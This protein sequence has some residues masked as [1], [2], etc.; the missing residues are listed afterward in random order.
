[1]INPL[2]LIL[3]SISGGVAGYITNK[4]AVNMLFKEYTPLKLGGVV[5]KNKEK[6]IDEISTLVEKD[7]I[8]GKTLKEHIHGEEFKK[9]LDI[10]VEEFWNSGLKEV[11]NDVKIKDISSFE[12]SK[13]SILEFTESKMKLVSDKLLKNIVDNVKITE[14][15]S[16]KHISYITDIVYEEAFKYIKSE[17]KI[18][19]LLTDIYHQNNSLII[20]DIIDE[21]TERKIKANIEEFII[22]SLEKILT[23]KEKLSNIIGR[24]CDV[25][26]IDEI[27]NNL[28][29]SIGSNT[30]NDYFSAEEKK[31]ISSALFAKGS[32]LINSDKGAYSVNTI[33]S[34]LIK[35]AK[36]LDFTLY[37]LLPEE[38][39]INLSKFIEEMTIKAIPSISE[40]IRFN[41]NE[42]NKII[43]DSIDESIEGMNGSIKRIIVQKVR[44][45]L[46]SDISEKASVVDKIISYID[47]YEINEESVKKIS[48]GIITYLESNKV[49]DIIVKL[50]EANIISSDKITALSKLIIEKI[51]IHGEKILNLLVES[52]FSKKISSFIT[53]ESVNLLKR[54]VKEELFLLIYKERKE[55]LS[56]LQPRVINSINNKIEEVIHTPM[57]KF[58]PEEKFTKFLKNVD[59][60][61]L[62]L[63]QNNKRE[64]LEPINT[65]IISKVAEIDLIKVLDNEKDKLENFMVKLVVNLEKEIISKYSENTL[66][67][68][69]DYICNKEKLIETSK[70]KLYKYID[71]NIEEM[72]NGNIKNIIYDNLIKFNEEE[73]CDLAQAFMGNE[74][75]PLSVFGGIL[76]LIVGCI[77]GLF[78]GNASI[79]GFSSSIGSTV[80]SCIIM[81]M[82]G[83]GTNVI[84][85]KMLFYPYKRNK[86]LAKIPFLRKFSL[87]YIPAHKDIMARGIGYVIDEELLNGERV[88]MLLSSKKDM[89]KGYLISSISESNYKVIM[90]SIKEKKET[91]VDFLYNGMKKNIENNKAKIAERAVEGIGNVSVEK[92]VKPRTISKIIL[93]T[94]KLSLIF[95]EKTADYLEDKIKT[96]KKCKEFMK[97]EQ[98]IKIRTDVNSS[99][100]DVLLNK[101]KDILNEEN[102]KKIILKGEDK[103]QTIIN[104]PLCEIISKEKSENLRKY[105]KDK[106]MLWI[107]NESESYFE[108]EISGFLQKE[109]DGDNTIGNVFGGKLAA[110]I[111]SNIPKLSRYVISKGENYLKANRNNFSEKVRN[112]I[113]SGLNFL[114]RGAYMMFGGDDIVDRCVDT[115][116]DIKVPIFLDNKYLE[117]TS[118]VQNTLSYSVYPTPI[119][120]LQLKAKEIN[121]SKVLDSIYISLN[122]S[123]YVKENI[124]DVIDEAINIILN[125]NLKEFLSFTDLTSLK[126][127]CHKFSNQLKLVIEVSRDNLVNNI[128]EIIK[129]TD[130]IID[131]EFI[132]HIQE[133]AINK[134]MLAV[135]REDIVRCTKGI[136]NIVVNNEQFAITLEKIANEFY[137]E[138][139]RKAS[140]NDF[141]DKEYS[142]EYM[143]A[144]IETAFNNKSFNDTNR[145]IINVIYE[146][147]INDGVN[148]IKEDTKDDV[149]CRVIE[150]V[151]NVTFNNTSELLKAVN[152]KQVT[153]EQIAIMEPKE[154]HIMFNGFAG[155]FFK[156]LYLY[157]S[158]G[159]IFG[160][161]LWLSIAWG[162]IEEINN[163]RTA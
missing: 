14:I 92:I 10:T 99:L 15:L 23:D 71:N 29:K 102:I 45:S 19:V 75:K 85:L 161:N 149:I 121:C 146:E 136:L 120:S 108:N 57:E 118:I 9:Q 26:D 48:E 49:K 115:I 86:F 41:K 6:F 156:K 54:N 44:D 33:L 64:I 150:A 1:M 157:G 21:A 13:E 79:S 46:F 68:F 103:Y 133:T 58:L 66:D 24:I 17:H 151:L 40:W 7:I 37:E 35:I 88:K 65:R 129:C 95:A 125:E 153:M 94:R 18:S 51:N 28:F 126:D 38:S 124:E 63:L 67:E 72:L 130:K 105:I 140:L 30:L 78:Y 81:A 135:K 110:Y 3:Q 159:A 132:Q 113:K 107:F 111:D 69:I 61:L 34:Q 127:I 114:E 89:F 52:I 142:I 122:K 137:E 11:F 117:I 50:E 93:D 84:A 4:Y 158:F 77:Y 152:L 134:V 148:F 39:S 163:K 98:F 55:I 128:D 47:S 22:N 106:S 104:K 109:I 2:F 90:D 82:I 73:I 91:I 145:E 141:I 162:I 112:Q 70:D 101:S 56:Y 100:K 60:S 25:I 147:I 139:V 97:E 8:N 80:I 20:K 42:V 143:K 131:E 5:K 76:G 43:E 116:I 87:G 32:A 59:S 53:E 138:V 62:Q 83:V 27:I 36:D 155:D 96:D 31:E 74:L 144:Y 154:I 12:E 119:K 123:Q 160:I 16:A